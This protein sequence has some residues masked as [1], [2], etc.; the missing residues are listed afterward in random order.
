[1]LEGRSASDAIAQKAAPPVGLL[2]VNKTFNFEPGAARSALGGRSKS[3][4]WWSNRKLPG[5]SKVAHHG[6][7]TV[8]ENCPGA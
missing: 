5:Y 8:F 7:W 1:M 3:R 6:R 4:Q 2:F